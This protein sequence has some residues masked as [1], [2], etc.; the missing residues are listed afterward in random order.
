MKVAD[1]TIQDWQKLLDQFKVANPNAKSG[2]AMRIENTIFTTARYYGGMR[3]NGEQYTY[4]E[5]KDPTQ[6]N[7]PDGTPY[8]AWLMV[9][10]D[11]LSWVTKELKKGKARSTIPPSS[12]FP[13]AFE[14]EDRPYE[15]GG[16]E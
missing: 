2:A 14:W 3:L 13:T 15:E 9:R 7:N 6:P 5:P 8:V 11:F 16:K 4:F 1:L 10:D 12:A